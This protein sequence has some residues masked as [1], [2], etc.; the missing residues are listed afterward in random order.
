[1]AI[2][3]TSQSTCSHRSTQPVEPDQPK[4]RV[5]PIRCGW[6]T[7]FA[8]S[9]LDNGGIVAVQHAVEH[10]VTVAD[11]PFIKRLGGFQSTKP[12]PTTTALFP[13]ASNHLALHRRESRRKYLVEAMHASPLT[14]M[15]G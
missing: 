13:F 6:I 15:G 3:T 7:A 14:S 1:M 2:T 11:I 12:A 8:R 10:L 4:I 9:S 5:S